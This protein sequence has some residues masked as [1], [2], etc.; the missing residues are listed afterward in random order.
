MA[1]EYELPTDWLNDGVKGYINQAMNQETY[2]SLSNL[3]VYSIDAKGL[4]AMKLTSARVDTKDMEDSIFLMNVLSIKEENTLFE[5][6][7]KYT[8]PSQRTIAS[9]FFT[10]EA[11]Q[12]YIRQ[13]KQED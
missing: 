4:L 2:I 6:I 13:L 12:K 1:E 3:D 11:F 5:I 8:H 7:E 10:K 9:K